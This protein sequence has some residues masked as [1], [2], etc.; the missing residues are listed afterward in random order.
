PEDGH[1]PCPPL[2]GVARSAGGCKTS[3]TRVLRCRLS[4]CHSERSEE[5]LSVRHFFPGI[6]RFA[7]NDTGRVFGGGLGVIPA[8]GCFVA[9]LLAM[10]GVM[11]TP[12]E[13]SDRSDPSD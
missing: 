2:K 11:D 12:S 8:S 5:S 10:T 13:P 4:M 3:H 6:L 1:R 7:Q 9:S